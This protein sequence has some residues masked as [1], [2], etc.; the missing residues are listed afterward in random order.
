[1]Q[2]WQAAGE[3]TGEGEP[4]AAMGE[5]PIVRY[6]ALPPTRAMTGGVTA[7]ALYAGTGVGHVRRTEPAAAITAR[8]LAAI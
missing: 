2:A 7:M 3:R 1:V 6:S 4:V 5:H 8:L